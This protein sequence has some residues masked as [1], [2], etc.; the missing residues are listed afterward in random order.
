[1]PASVTLHA[2][3]LDRHIGRFSGRAYG[4][5]AYFID[6]LAASR[7]LSITRRAVRPIDEEIDRFW[8]HGLPALS[9]F[10]FPVMEVDWGSTIEMQRR[11][12]CALPLQDVAA[13]TFTKAI[14]K[15]RRH[16]ADFSYLWR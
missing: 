4:T 10:P 5:Q 16:I 13:V 11:A 2:D 8:A 15:A 3:Y 7:F 12:P 14:E 9:V 6:A 1:M